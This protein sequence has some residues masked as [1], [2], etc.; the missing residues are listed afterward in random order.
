MKLRR[1]RF[2][3]RQIPKIFE[4]RIYKWNQKAHRKEYAKVIEA[5]KEAIKDIH[6]DHNRKLAHTQAE[7]EIQMLNKIL[8][9]K[10][11]LTKKELIG[12]TV[13]LVRTETRNIGS[14]RKW[15]DYVK[16]ISVSPEHKIEKLTDC[17]V[18][19][20]NGC[21]NKIYYSNVIAVIF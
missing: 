8:A 3:G 17:K 21:G 20:I 11:P 10:R 6:V 1:N 15:A 4:R 16:K 19:F 7:A 12:K 13:K 14:L 2:G 5:G 9:K 18:M